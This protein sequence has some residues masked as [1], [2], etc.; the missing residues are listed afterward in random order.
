MKLNVSSGW[1]VLVMGWDRGTVSE[2][3]R[4]R[5]TNKDIKRARE[6]KNYPNNLRVGTICKPL[7]ES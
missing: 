7:E 3:M 6:R 2:G 4:E 1:G 5:E